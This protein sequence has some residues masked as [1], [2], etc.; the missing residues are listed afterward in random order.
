MRKEP[1]NAKHR[2]FLF[3]LLSVMGQWGRALTS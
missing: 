1:S 3:Q 2:V